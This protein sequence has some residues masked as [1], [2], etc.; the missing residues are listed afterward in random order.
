M[1]WMQFC[2]DPGISSAGKTLTRPQISLSTNVNLNIHNSN[3][4]GNS[5]S[6]NRISDAN[7]RLEI[8]TNYGCRIFH[9][10]IFHCW[11]L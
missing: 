9:T 10:S 6:K 7:L 1:L 8:V 5:N 3:S 2:F 11:A 4:E